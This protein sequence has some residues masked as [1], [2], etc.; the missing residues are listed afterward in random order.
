MH[1][2]LFFFF[3]LKTCFLAGTKHQLGGE[4]CESQCEGEGLH[5]CVCFGLDLQG[6][7]KSLS[8][9]AR[10]IGSASD[11]NYAREF[12]KQM[13]LPLETLHD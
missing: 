7:A 5:V 6:L 11:G 8:T 13:H 4:V 9:K 2:H 10:R 1:V 3:V 12:W